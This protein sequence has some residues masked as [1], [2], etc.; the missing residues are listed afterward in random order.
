MRQLSTILL[1]PVRCI[2]IIMHDG[3]RRW[4][5]TLREVR[6]AHDGEIRRD[7]TRIG[8]DLLIINH[9][10]RCSRSRSKSV[11]LQAQAAQLGSRRARASSQIMEA[12]KLL[13]VN[14][15]EHILACLLSKARV[16][17]EE[18]GAG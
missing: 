5:L 18:D 8:S 17:G 15:R 4:S 7:E 6:R 16:S 2:K 3:A 1:T 14:W 11:T 9:R 12:F 10:F 13:R